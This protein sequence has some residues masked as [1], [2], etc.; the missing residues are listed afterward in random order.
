MAPF[1]FFFE[2]FLIFLHAV[3]PDMKAFLNIFAK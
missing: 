1:L 3:K 2:I